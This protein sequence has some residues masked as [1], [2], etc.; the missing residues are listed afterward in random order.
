MPVSSLQGNS[1]RETQTKTGY[2]V[3]IL[4]ES[5]HESYFAINYRSCQN[6]LE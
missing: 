2:L 3:R 4:E 1:H 5:A 6:D